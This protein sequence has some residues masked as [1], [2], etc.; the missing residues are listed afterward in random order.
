MTEKHRPLHPR[1]TVLASHLNRPFR[2][3]YS[4]SFKLFYLLQQYVNDSNDYDNFSDKSLSPPR[5]HYVRSFLYRQKNRFATQATQTSFFL[6]FL[7]ISGTLLPPPAHMSQLAHVASERPARARVERIPTVDWVSK[8]QP[9]SL[10][11]CHTALKLAPPRRKRYT[12]LS[13]KVKLLKLK[14]LQKRDKIHAKISHKGQLC[15]A[16]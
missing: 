10:R 14:L 13:R 11:V 3:F 8:I 7:R 4:H 16:P 12:L 5:T 2:V 1:D 9:D 15:V 6:P